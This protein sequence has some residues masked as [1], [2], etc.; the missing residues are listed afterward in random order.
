MRRIGLLTRA[1]G[2]AAPPWLVSMVLCVAS[3]VAMTAVA[4]A[5]STSR[6]Q[7]VV[8]RAEADLT[9]ET[10]FIEGQKLL[11]N[12]DTEVFVTL[13]GTPLVVLSATDSQ[14]FARLPP[15]LA[16]GTYLLRVS[17]GTGAVQNGTFD[18][19]VGAVGP[20]GPTGPK[21]DMGNTGPEGLAGATGPQ[22]PVGLTGATG[23]QGPVGATGAQ[24]LTGATGPQGLTGP[25]GP[26]G[27]VGLT[28]ATGP[29]GPS[30]PAGA[31]GLNARGAWS[32]ADSYVLDD[33]VTD[34]G[35]TWRCLAANCTVGI[36][37]TLEIQD[38][39]WELLAAKGADGATGEQG[40]QG[41]TGPTGP[42]GSNGLNGGPGPAGP[43]GPT[44]PTGPAGPTGPTGTATH[45]APPCFDN[46]NRYV[47]C[48]N[49]TVTDTVTGLIWLKDANCFSTK[50]YSPA[51]QAAAGL[52]AGQ[53]GLTDG[54]SAGDWRLPTKV[55]WEAT[56]ARAVALGCKILS[57]GGPPSLTN[58]AGTGCLSAGPT[59]FTGV[60]SSTTSSYWSSSAHEV[61]PRNAWVMVLAGGS[62][63]DGFK[64]GSSFVWPVRGGQ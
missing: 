43:T 33:V 49:G 20:A 42:A 47:D 24:G 40:P 55:E 27:L 64:G 36:L 18:L 53:C 13:A 28:G 11:W 59:S 58:N 57:L 50:T 12:N 15:G 32:D 14:V 21:G 2:R 45:A 16:P 5:Q 22:G 61:D 37:P 7:L 9:A 34:A 1:L 44:G 30:G 3:A 17:R 48:S 23:S 62:F 8:Q 26:Q 39:D 41:P 60:Q 51:N 35:Q 19:T 63:L 52:A 10:L 29:T 6:P 25:T 54:S 4:H 38:P 31:K 46:L 56:V